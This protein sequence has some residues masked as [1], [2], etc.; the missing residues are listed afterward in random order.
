MIVDLYGMAPRSPGYNVGA[1]GR[2]IRVLIQRDPLLKGV[3]YD[4]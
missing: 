2:I 3:I 4:L 1:I